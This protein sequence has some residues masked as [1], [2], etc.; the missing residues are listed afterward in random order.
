[1]FRF[2]GFAPSYRFTPPGAVQVYFTPVALMGFNPSGVFPL[3]KLRQL[4]AVR[5]ALVAFLPNGHR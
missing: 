4:I 3:K 5:R 1:M 2:Q